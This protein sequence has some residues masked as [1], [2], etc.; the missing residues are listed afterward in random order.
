MKKLTI[1]I[2]IFLTAMALVGLIFIQLFWIKNAVSLAEQQYDHRVA[3][4]LQ[5]VVDDLVELNNEKFKIELQEHSL[6]CSHFQASIGEV[7]DTLIVDSLLKK[8]FEIF[9]V[10]TVYEYAIVKCDESKTLF[11][12][13]NIISNNISFNSHKTCLS[14]IWKKEC[15][16][17]ITY[18][19]MK[20]IF[21]L[22]ELIIWLVLSG[23]FLLIVVAS[24]IFIVSAIFRQKKIS[25]MK[26]DFINNMT[27]EFKTPIST[28]LMATE[29]LLKSGEKS[30]FDRIKKYSQ[31]IYDENQRLRKQVERVLQMAILDR[32]KN[33]L[34]LEKVDIH[35]LLRETVNSLCLDHCE[36]PV[37]IIYNF[38]SK[39][40]EICIDVLHISNVINNLVDN[41][42][43]YSKD[44]KTITISTKDDNKGIYIV[45]EDNGI[46]MTKDV[47]KYIFDKF[48]RVPTGNIHDV[49]GFGIGLHYVKS[50]VEAHGGKIRVHSEF[51]KGSIFTVFLP[52]QNK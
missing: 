8:Y 34:I 3:L 35:E 39:I 10:D 25:E 7:I 30:S 5:K 51:N 44:K 19:P 15:Y 11:G 45:V 13:D 18:F 41:A 31:I 6:E 20:R 46:G 32:G 40:D 2:I 33:K 37:E 12:A 42:N 24:F 16:N 26:N 1:K 38:N 50:I 17:L 47:L 14:C 29:V 9:C 43:K 22:S 4:A 28:V 48:Y 36:F 49:K 21:V 52:F 23:F 27:H